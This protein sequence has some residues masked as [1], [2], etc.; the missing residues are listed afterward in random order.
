MRLQKHHRLALQAVR[1]LCPG[2]KA[3]LHPARKHPKL[4]AQYAGRVVQITVSSSPACVE[5]VVRH[6][7]RDVLNR[8]ESFGVAIRSLHG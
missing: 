1:G 3:Q 5:D 6:S 4:V 2:M 8:F 7:V